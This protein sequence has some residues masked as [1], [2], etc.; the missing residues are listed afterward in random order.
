MKDALAK[1]FK[2]TVAQVC[3]ETELC[4]CPHKQN[5]SVFLC[6][7]YV[8][9]WLSYNALFSSYSWIKH[10]TDFCLFSQVK[11]KPWLPWVYSWIR[12]RHEQF[13]WKKRKLL[14]H[15]KSWLRLSETQ[16]RLTPY[17]V[18]VMFWGIKKK[19]G[20]ITKNFNKTV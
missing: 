5:L 9:P 11:N 15:A 1:C 13:L 16:L 2:K 3:T 6:V 10:S 14:E 19:N 4:N 12:H 17:Y 8:L 20:K 18:C 7:I